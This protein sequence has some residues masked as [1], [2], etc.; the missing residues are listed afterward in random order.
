MMSNSESQAKGKKIIRQL[1][2]GQERNDLLDQIGEV[3]PDFLS[4]ITEDQLF[5]FDS[6]EQ[7]IDS[8]IG[9]CALD[10]EK[11]VCIAASGAVCA[12][13][14]EIQVNTSRKYQGQGLATSVSAA[15]ILECLQLGIDPN[16]DAATE[17]SAGLAKKLGYSPLGE[18][19]YYF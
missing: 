15:L 3:C 5:G 4:V 8:G 14:I 17:K 10:G 6:P 13:G 9:Y 12:K 1:R 16:W 7:F 2:S 11:M 18:Y 19:E